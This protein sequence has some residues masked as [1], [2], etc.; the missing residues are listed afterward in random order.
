MGV[1]CRHMAVRGGG[2]DVG[3]AG[4]KGNWLI[5]KDIKLKLLHKI[6]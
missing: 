4:R 6:T 1:L 3:I 2:G 5:I